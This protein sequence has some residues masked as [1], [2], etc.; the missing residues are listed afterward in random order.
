[1]FDEIECEDWT[2]ETLEL[3]VPSRT[4]YK[5]HTIKHWL[6]W[7]QDGTLDPT[8]KKDTLIF[9]A[10]H[11]VGLNYKRVVVN[12]RLKLILIRARNNYN[13]LMEN[14]VTE[15]EIELFKVQW[16]MPH[17]SL[18]KI[19]KLSMLRALENGCYLHEFS[20]VGSVR[21]SSITEY[22]A[23]MGY[24]NGDST[25]EAAICYLC[26]TDRLKECH[27]TRCKRVRRL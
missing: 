12:A 9:A 17:V 8:Q 6:P 14:P 1:M 22:Q 13:C 7:T 19:N 2:T 5:W 20:L 4:M 18:N 15:P 11:A 10:Q 27:V 26:S 25:W 3:P 23:F 21:V 24:Q 16:R